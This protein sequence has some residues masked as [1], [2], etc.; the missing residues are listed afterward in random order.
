MMSIELTFLSVFLLLM[1]AHTWHGARKT[2]SLSDYLV[3]GR[4]L[5]GVGIALSFF[6]TFVSSVTFV[7][8]AGRSWTLGPAWWIVCTVLFTTAV[9]ISWFVIAPRF[10]E[11]AEKYQLLTI[12]EFLGVRY[13]SRTLQRIS[14]IVVVVA[15]LVYM[16]AVY[17]GAARTLEGL[18]KID[19]QSVMAVV[20]IVVTGY[21]L[22]GGFHAVVATDGVQGVMLLC[23]AVTLPIVMLYRGGGI[24]SVLETIHERAPLALRFSSG[25]PLLGLIGTAL[26]IALKI[27]VDPRLLS[28]FYGLS[29]GQQVLRGRWLA[30][31]LLFVTY[32][33]V[34]PVGLLAHAFVPAGLELQA[35]EVVPWLLSSDG[36][37]LG[38][39]A[40]SLFLTALVAAAMSSLDSVL[41]VAAGSIERDITTQPDRE[42][43]GGSVR[44]TRIWV[45]VLSAAAA[46]LALLRTRGIVELSSLSGGLYAVCFLPALIVGLFWQGAT[47]TA[48][49]CSLVS[50]FVTA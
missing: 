2:D 1:L 21:T 24:S 27:I 38:T 8:L 22:L 41:L 14:G 48:A 19:S 18:L 37:V 23:G 46:S 31:V 32:L 43:D 6:A 39:I 36:H 12:P 4:S 28:R 45:F 35:D 25:L 29:S 49:I 15:S 40:G 9:L 42:C 33:F 47:K 16:T 26:G 7:G 34:L 50:G 5:G 44:R 11:F 30:V 17:D 3:G 13:Q 10:L 20:F